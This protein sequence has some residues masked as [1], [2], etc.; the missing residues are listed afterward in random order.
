MSLTVVRKWFWSEYAVTPRKMSSK[1]L[2]RTFASSACSSLKLYRA[3]ISG[4]AS[5]I[6]MRWWFWLGSTRIG[7]RCTIRYLLRPAP[8]MTHSHPGTAVA[9]MESGSDVRYRKL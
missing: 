7:F 1:R 6:L 5:G 2:Y 3:T 9:A 8:S 4:V